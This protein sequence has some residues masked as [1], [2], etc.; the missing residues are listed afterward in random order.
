MPSDSRWRHKADRRR[1]FEGS[2][3]GGVGIEMSD[4]TITIACTSVKV[5]RSK[6]DPVSIISTSIRVNINNKDV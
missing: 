5:E 4:G 6:N 3:K 2:D 1:I